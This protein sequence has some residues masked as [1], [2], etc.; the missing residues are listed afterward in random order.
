MLE[1][2]TKS[3]IP[4]YQFGFRNNPNIEQIHSMVSTIEAQRKTAQ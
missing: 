1:I 2:T 3:Q 4:D